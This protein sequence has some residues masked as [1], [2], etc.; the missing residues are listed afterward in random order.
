VLVGELVIGG[1]AVRRDRD[2]VRRRLGEIEDDRFAGIGEIEAYFLGAANRVVHRGGDVEG[3]LVSEVGDVS[4]AVLGE[5]PGYTG[6]VGFDG[7][8]ATV[9]KCGG[10][11][12]SKDL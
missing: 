9:E 5:I 1:L 12:K 7:A 3:D 8:R 10:K 11:T 6:L 2:D 4:R